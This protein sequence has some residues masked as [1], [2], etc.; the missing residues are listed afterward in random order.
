MINHLSISASSE[1]LILPTG[2]I[3]NRQNG[4]IKLINKPLNHAKIT[5]SLI[6]TFCFVDS[7]H[8]ISNNY[9]AC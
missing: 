2:K 8:S 6:N 3:C 4:I 5:N 1:A 7:K 9:M